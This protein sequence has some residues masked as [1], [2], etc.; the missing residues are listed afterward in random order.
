MKEDTEMKKIYNTPEMN[1]LCVETKDVITL[2]AGENGSIT[3]FTFSG[4]LNGSAGWM[5][6]SDSG[7]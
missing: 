6:E 3:S 4:I 1:M 7:F 2:S 5:T